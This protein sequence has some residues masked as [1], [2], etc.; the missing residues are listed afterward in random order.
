LISVTGRELTTSQWLLRSLRL[1]GVLLVL[2]G[3][4][5]VLGL[6]VLFS[7]TGESMEA[8]ERQVTR[9]VVGLVALLA[10]ARIPVSTLRAWSPWLFLL[11]VALL[12]AV[13]LAGDVGKGAR[14]WLDLGVIRFQPS[15]IM[16]LAM[17]LMVAWYLSLRN[18]PPRFIDLL[19][20]GVLIVVPVFLI[21]RQPD[22]GTALLVAAAGLLVVFLAGL[23][24]RWF[25]GLGLVIAAAIPALWTQLHDYQRQRVLT[26]LNPESD[27][28]GA[29]YHIIQSKIAIGSGGLYGKGWLNGTQSQLQFLPER[30]TDFVFAVYA[31]E[32]GFVGISVLL[33]LYFLIVARGLWIAAAAQDRFSRLI[34]GSISLT[35]AV[36]MVVNIGMVSGVLPV[37]GVPLPLVSY[38]GTSLVTLMVGFGILMAV[39]TQQR[40]VNR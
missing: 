27:P 7:A 4:L 6:V 9:I 40:L 1:D 19:V 11:G 29:G 15:E 25:V 37:V 12:V 34:A 2:I 22:L 23:G 14:R 16:K 21:M 38:G 18:L 31:E 36:Y 5:L 28:L 17:P 13:M 30:S 20:V 26:L 8:L 10:V 35:F 39:H 3:V 24:W 33:A 32:F